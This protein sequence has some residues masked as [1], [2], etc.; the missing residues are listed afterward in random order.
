MSSEDK[1]ESDDPPPAAKRVALDE[2]SQP[3]FTDVA[4]VI[5]SHHLSASTRHSLLNHHFRPDANYNF[6]K[7]STGTGRSFQLQWLQSFP[8]LVYS[9]QTDG[10]FCLPCV[11]FAPSGYHG[12]NPGVLVTR[13]LTNFKKALEMLHKHTDKEHHKVAIVRAEE[14][15]RSMSG[16]QPDIQQRMSKSLAERISTNRQKLSIMKTILFCGRQN[17]ALRGHRDSAL[18]IERDVDDL[19][20]HGN[21][22]AL[23]NFRI[24]AGDSVLE[25]HLSTAARN[26][27]Y[28]SNTIQK[29]IISILADQV[30]QSIISRVKAAKCFSVIADEVTDVSN[31]EQLSIALRY[32]DSA[33]LLVRE[34]LVGF[35]ECDTGISG[36]NL[37]RKITSTLEELGLD[38]EHLRGQAYDGAGNMAGSVKGTAALICSHYP[39][40]MYL[41]CSSHCLNLAVVKSLEVTSVRNMMAVVGRVYQFFSAHPKCQGAFEKAVSERQPSSS[42]RKLKDMCRTRWLQRIDAADIFMRLYL[43]VVE[44]LENICNDGAR[45]WSQDSLTDARGLLLAITTTDFVSTLVITNSCLKYLKALTASLQAEAK[46]IVTAVSEIDTVTATVQDVRDNIDTHH[47]Q[48]FLTITEMLSVV[49]IEP[50]VPRR[51]GRQTQ[52]SNVPADT[53]SEYF[54]RTISIPVLDHLLCELR[55][56][57]GKHQRRALLGF[58]IV[59]SLFV[60][61]ESDDHISRFKALSDLYESDLPSPECLE[62]ELHSWQIKWRR[63]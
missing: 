44:C 38:L 19:Q 34:D 9:K 27:T 2:A 57:F 11:L 41:H 18:D 15:E 47:A 13:P 54:R 21:F 40:A 7:D 3:L 26:A 10:G 51:C 55:S 45:L 36:R 52:W 25:Q 58:S 17:I 42:S 60:S 6:P 56:R 29:Q 50:S 48:W 32:V 62:S 28:T 59:P 14:F 31:K 16:Q 8:W 61:L 63:E 24:D 5:G 37:A 12:S 33:T 4:Q 49:G 23:L 20:N 1:T 39:L 35:F 43:S 46:D 22:V 30:I 53:P